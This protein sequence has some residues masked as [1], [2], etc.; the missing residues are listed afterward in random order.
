MPGPSLQSLLVTSVTTVVVVAA[1]TT[2]LTVYGTSA[3]TSRELAERMQHTVATRIEREIEPWLAAPHAL[4]LMNARSVTDEGWPADDALVRRFLAQLEAEPAVSYVQLGRESDGAFVGVERSVDGVFTLEITDAGHTGKSVFPLGADGTASGPALGSVPG[5]DPR[6]RPWY[7][8]AAQSPGPTWSPIYQFS[9]RQVTRLGI[10]AVLPV[11]G[12]D[13]Q[14]IGVA[15]ADLELTHLS[16]LLREAADDDS[17]RLAVVEPT[18]ALV[19][20]SVGAP[21]AVESDG[22]A[23]RLT[24]EE[25]D[26]PGLR[27][28]ARAL[29]ELWAG[30]DHRYADGVSVAGVHIGDDRG[31]SWL[32]V[33]VVPDEQVFADLRANAWRS[34]VLT[35]AIAA[36][37]AA[38]GYALAERSTSSLRALA[39]SA[40]HLAAGRFHEPL[41]RAHI[42]EVDA[43]VRSFEGM[44]ATIEATLHD[45]EHARQIAEAGSRA[46]SAFLAS[47][48]HELRTPLNAILGYTELLADSLF[49]E[50][51]PMAAEQDLAKIRIAGQHLLMLIGD[52]LD[53]AR[54]EAGKLELTL[55]GVAVGP[56]VHGVADTIRP[57]VEARGN[58]LRVT[59]E[60]DLGEVWADPVRLRQVLINLLGNAGKFTD[61]GLVELV[62]ARQ[63][64]QVRFEVRDTGAGIAPERLAA[65][66]EPFTRVESAAGREG[67]GL[68]LAIVR[69]LVDAMGGTVSVQS[70]RGKG[71]I[72]AVRFP[73]PPSTGG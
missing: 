12:P 47:V 50:P 10:T 49:D 11:E 21:F 39:V 26:D 24:L 31:L 56:L 9:S 20:V 27:A 33:T 13:G 51:D 64:D 7:Q 4:N 44:R 69:H 35:L 61:Q 34:L 36:V 2:G 63:G 29:P 40:Q 8:R 38:V 62:V 16:E 58:V 19:A 55:Q 1:L 14:R 15:G 25:L 42:A 59:L 68:G 67:A 37:G 71:S 22:T 73:R 30:A 45:A 18:G 60:R 5:Y 70:E 65:V 46:K 72:F 32:L 52:V 41:P 54:L 66:F 48:S 17:A 28:A 23:R 53:L 6:A 3:R 57:A 43:L